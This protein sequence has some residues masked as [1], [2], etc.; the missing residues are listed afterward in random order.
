MINKSL[1][2]FILSFFALIFSAAADPTEEFNN[3][4]YENYNEIIGL[5]P[6]QEKR[7]DVGIFYDFK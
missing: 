7:N 6:F 3:K 1:L 4:I 2:I 5:Y